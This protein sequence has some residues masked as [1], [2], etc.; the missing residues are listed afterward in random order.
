[1]KDERARKRKEVKD[2]YERKTAKVKYEYEQ[3]TKEI[4]TEYDR[5]ARSITAQER[6]FK[7]ECARYPVERYNILK[8]QAAAER[9]VEKYGDLLADELAKRKAKKAKFDGNRECSYTRETYPDSIA[10]LGQ[11]ER[12]NGLRSGRQRM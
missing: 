2:E 5:E 9:G 7:D 12:T 4:Q 8:C 10:T 11:C 3:K 1:M 6:K